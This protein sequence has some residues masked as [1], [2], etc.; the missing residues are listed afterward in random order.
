MS[1]IGNYTNPDF[2]AL[3]KA[4]KESLHNIVNSPKRLINR[5]LSI[6]NNTIP[7]VRRR[8]NRKSKSHFRKI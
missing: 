4:Q 8:I 2:E 1:R 6:I 5:V 7:K 3:V